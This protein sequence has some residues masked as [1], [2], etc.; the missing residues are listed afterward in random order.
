M[1]FITLLT[2]L[3]TLKSAALTLSGTIQNRS[4]LKISDTTMAFIV[5]K[6]IPTLLDDGTQGVRVVDTLH[7]LNSDG[8]F[9]ITDDSLSSLATSEAVTFGV[10][11]IVNPPI[12]GIPSFPKGLRGRFYYGQ[13]LYNFPIDPQQGA[14]QNFTLVE[15]KGFFTSFEKINERFESFIEPIELPEGRLVFRLPPFSQHVSTFTYTLSMQEKDTQKVVGSFSFNGHTTSLPDSFPDTFS[16]PLRAL[17][18]E[19][20][21]EL[22]EHYSFTTYFDGCQYTLFDTIKS[23][24]LSE[25]PGVLSVDFLDAGDWERLQVEVTRN[26]DRQLME[27]ALSSEYDSLCQALLDEGRVVATDSTRGG[28]AF[29]HCVKNPQQILML[30]DAGADPLLRGVYN[31][32]VY[33]SPW[34]FLHN[35]LYYKSDSVD[36]EAYRRVMREL[37]DRNLYSDSIL[38]IAVNVKDPVLLEQALY[39]GA[40]IDTSNC[41]QRPFLDAICNGD[42]TAVRIFLDY[43]ALDLTQER[44]EVYPLDYARKMIS[45]RETQPY[46][47]IESMLIEAGA[48][49]KEATD[50]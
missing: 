40:T 17:I 32:R 29:I 31:S 14:V 25:F 26:E 19:G 39:K 22:T 47:S 9:H 5:K 4:S 41:E 45:L 38:T 20:V 48:V 46:H 36:A 3:L 7:F 16:L 30:V 50:K 37:L 33:E 43:D 49:G 42:T 44:W 12:E 35:G 21:A 1:R 6:H 2:L 13:H 34:A 27:I 8:T 24:S 28:I 11:G 18:P 10:E 15:K 23:V